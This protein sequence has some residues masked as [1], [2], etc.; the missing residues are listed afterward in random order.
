MDFKLKT[1]L[2]KKIEMIKEA[3][4]EKYSIRARCVMTDY[5]SICDHILNKGGS[6]VELCNYLEVLEKI[7][8]AGGDLAVLKSIKEEE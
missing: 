5:L 6:L 8:V 1:M 4:V 7:T 2:R 3:D